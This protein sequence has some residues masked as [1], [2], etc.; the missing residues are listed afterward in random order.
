MEVMEN[1]SRPYSEW[2]PAAAHQLAGDGP[3]D[4]LTHSLFT[5]ACAWANADSER[6]G[7]SV[8]CALEAYRA[9]GGKLPDALQELEPD[10]IAELPKD[11]M[12]GQDLVYH[13]GDEFGEDGYVLYS[14]GLDGKDGGGLVWSMHE[15]TG[16]LVFGPR[17]D[18]MSG[19][20]AP[21]PV[22]GAMEWMEGLQG[23]GEA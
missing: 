8:R 17:W 23:P 16:D 14:V 19:R 9:E 22:G 21:E 10:Y 2:G 6:T 5:T 13:T 3:R 11:P 7:L 20:G 1:V 15:A 18:P 12:S 4:L